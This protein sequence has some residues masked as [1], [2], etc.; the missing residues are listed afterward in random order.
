MLPPL[1]AWW[2]CTLELTPCIYG[3]LVNTS[4]DFHILVQLVPRV[5]YYSGEDVFNPV[6]Y[7]HLTL[8]TNSLV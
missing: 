1:N 6:S 8:P 3:M 4:V 2:A 7:T 5:T